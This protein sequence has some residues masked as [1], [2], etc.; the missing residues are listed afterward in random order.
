MKKNK[1]FTLIEVLV[2]AVIVIVLASVGVSSYVNISRKSRDARRISDFEQIRAALEMYR[3][4]NGYYP[5]T[6]AGNWTAMSNLS[7]V[8]VS[9]YV[10]A[11]P[12][13]P[14]DVTNVYQYR[15]TNASGGQYYGYCLASRFEAASGTVNNCTPVAL[16]NSNYNYGLRHP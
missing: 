3:S 10:Q 11:I 14:R 12:A 9:N 5:N 8:L 2:A 1:G 13:D 16:P 15:A 7:A 6:G 4:D